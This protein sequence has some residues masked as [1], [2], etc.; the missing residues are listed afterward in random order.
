MEVLEASGFGRKR[1]PSVCYLKKAQLLMGCVYSKF[2]AK[3]LICTFSLHSL[4]LGPQS[5][6]AGESG[7]CG[8]CAAPTA[9][10]S[11]A[12]SAP[13]PSPSTEGGCVTGWRWLQTTA[14]AASAHRVGTISVS[15][16]VSRDV[17]CSCFWQPVIHHDHRCNR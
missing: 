8:P 1:Q 17:Y 5:T 9:R 15:I 3:P 7:P 6:A 12:E 13:L 14:P 11:A 16:S 4:C 10:G 2:D